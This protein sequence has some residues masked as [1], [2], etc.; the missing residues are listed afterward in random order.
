MAEHHLL[1]ELNPKSLLIMDNAAFHK[2]GD[3]R[4]IAKTHGHP[5]VFL[6]ASS[7]EYSP[8]EEDFAILKKQRIYAQPG[9]TLDEIVK[10]YGT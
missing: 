7:P 1:P 10:L 8:I 4:A 3:I 9:T 6:P 5:V 2:Q